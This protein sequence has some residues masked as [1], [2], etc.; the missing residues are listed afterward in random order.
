[1][2]HSVLDTLIYYG[3]FAALWI[4]G[5]DLISRM[6]PLLHKTYRWMLRH[7]VLRPLR[8]AGRRARHYGA[9]LLRWM[10]RQLWQ[11]TLYLGRQLGRGIRYTWVRLTT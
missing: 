9:R 6:H 11:L 4:G 5:L 7:L 10:G 3:I 1:M 8:W 2:H